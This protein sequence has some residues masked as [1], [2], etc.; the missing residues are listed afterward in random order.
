MPLSYVIDPAARIVTITGE[1]SEPT[2][3]RRVLE[4]ISR[5]SD[6]GPGYGF[7]RDLRDSVTPVSA[8]SV[9]GIVAVV[10]EF[11]P[12]LRPSRAALLVNPGT[13]DAPPF[14]ALALAEDEPMPF[15]LFTSYKEAAAWVRG[16]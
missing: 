6:Y 13:F 8:E 11:W 1:Y 14:I 4:E 5:N 2:E 7:I 9:I 3:W 12:R 15:H 16:E 10:R